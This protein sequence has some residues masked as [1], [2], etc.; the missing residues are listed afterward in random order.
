MNSEN[1]QV[2]KKHSCITNMY[3]E[4]YKLGVNTIDTYFQM[5]NNSAKLKQLYLFKDK[6][7]LAI[8]FTTGERKNDN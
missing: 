8:A 2:I 7:H 1:L 3:K 6:K 5:K 4:A